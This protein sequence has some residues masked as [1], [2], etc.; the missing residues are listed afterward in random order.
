MSKCYM[1]TMP[2][3]EGMKM[4]KQFA[5]IKTYIWNHDCHKWVIGAETG[6]GGY[7]HWQIR[8][9]LGNDEDT[10]FASIKDEITEKA[11]IEKAS[12]TWSYERKEGMF[13]A[14]D[15]TKEIHQTRFGHPRGWQKW[16]LNALRSQNVRQVDL[17]YNP[18]GNEG[19]SWLV[20]HLYETGQA[21][22]VPVTEGAE[23]IIKTVA[24]L[25]DKFGKR[26]IICIDIPRTVK[27]NDGIYTVIETLKDG[28]IMDPR[29]TAT[30]MN[31]RGT[32][33][34]VFTNKDVDK[35]KLSV[36]RWKCYHLENGMWYEF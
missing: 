17:W 36:D 24:S 22:Y 10:V 5:K 30:P 20:N 13:W 15:D 25:T 18:N 11:H 4:C 23:S 12:D 1:I 9:M 29:Y 14:Y 31:I 21:W 34:I 26:P 2:R 32:R 7:K 3:G 8:M 27:W 6:K 35:A 33:V 28:L 16:A 19:K